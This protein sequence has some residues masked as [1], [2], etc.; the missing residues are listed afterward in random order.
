MADG[1]LRSVVGLVDQWGE[2]GE[3]TPA[4]RLA[5]AEA[6]L[7]LRMMDKAWVR[8]KAL[9][10]RREAGAKPHRLSARVFLDRGWPSKARKI[11][12][13]GLEVEPDDDAL[14]ALW[15]E[16]SEEPE[17]FDSSRADD[18]DADNDLLVEVAEHFMAQGAFVRAA[19]LLERVRRDDPAHGRAGDLLWA[20]RGEYALEEPLHQ[21]VERCAPDL[22]TLAEL[23]DEGDHTESADLGAMPLQIERDNND[24]R[25][26]ALFRHLEPTDADQ[27]ADEGEVT[28][29]SSLA[30]MQQL[31][32][33][34]RDERDPTEAA[35][36][37]QI[38]RVVHKAGALEPVSSDEAVH[39]TKG[40]VDSS[41]NLADFRREMGM[42]VDVAS[43][44]DYQI[45]ES[46]DD[47]VVVVTRKEI[48]EQH[49]ETTSKG[50][51]LD[52]EADARAA[53][54]QGQYREEEW[55]NLADNEPTQ[56]PAVA[57]APAEAPSPP[58]PKA[59]RSAGH[60]AATPG[61]VFSWPWWLA[62]LA[63]VMAFGVV[64]FGLLTLLLML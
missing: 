24:D 22:A 41:F 32:E 8:L 64:T 62:V 4:A 33:L 3:P 12:Q 28:A 11:V 59:P 61:P 58:Q 36:D 54:V 38:M 46:E 56:P 31:A 14:Q 16:A 30:E 5:Q 2:F 10:E 25:F 23:S 17:P 39:G 60:E 53:A 20:L 49:T 19:S 34:A 52:T 48:E 6:F 63:L 44:L 55:A 13:M 21:V 7:R 43:D 15:E 40:Q 9:I 27:P 42:D 26:P 45:P 51:T 57:D 37:T 50:L 1:E 35:E 47:S 18:P 29:V